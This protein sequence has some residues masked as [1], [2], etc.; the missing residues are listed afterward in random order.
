M[1]LR[2]VCRTSAD[3]GC[4]RTDCIPNGLADWTAADSAGF[5]SGYY[6]EPTH[7]NA[8]RSCTSFKS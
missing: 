5:G 6:F 2:L 3:I 7:G 4:T 1:G 8:R